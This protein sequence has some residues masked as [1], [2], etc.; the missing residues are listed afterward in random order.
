[1]AARGHAIAP[2]SDG[3][4][5]ITLDASSR[6]EPIITDLASRGASLVS[7]APQVETLE[8]VFVRRI[9]SAGDARAGEA[10]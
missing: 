2:L 3:T 6:P 1:V 10:R 7:A 9:A 5:Q 8:E 4:W